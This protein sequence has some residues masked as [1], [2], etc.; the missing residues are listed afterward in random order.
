MSSGMLR[1]PR[2]RINPALWE[3]GGRVARLPAPYRPGAAPMDEMKTPHR[4][5]FVTLLGRP[6]VG[7]STLL[8]QLL[9]EKV[10]A[11]SSRPQTT[12]NRIPGILTRPDAQIVFVDTPGIHRARSALN[13]Y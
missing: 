8:N 11:V 1:A 13:K 5:G 9:G 7:K 12:R 6:N 4:T 3:T 2:V 10:A